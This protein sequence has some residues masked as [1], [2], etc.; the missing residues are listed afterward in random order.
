MAP[1]LEK[2][3]QADDDGFELV[4]PMD[5]SPTWLSSTKR[6][7]PETIYTQSRKRLSRLDVYIFA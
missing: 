1:V 5:G 7:T 2:E 3:I 6:S 4:L